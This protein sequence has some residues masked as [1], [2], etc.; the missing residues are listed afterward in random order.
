ME[1]LDTTDSTNAELARRWNAGRAR[2]GDVLR[3]RFQSAGRGRAGREFV[4]KKDEALLISTLVKLPAH[5]AER[6]GWL[7]LAT[8]LAMRAAVST[9]TLKWPNDLQIEGK[10]LGGVLGELLETDPFVAVLGCG[11]NTTATDPYPGA[12]SLALAGLD[13]TPGRVDEIAET[14]IDELTSRITLITSGDIDPLRA[15]LR[16]HLST[17]G[18]SITASV[19]GGPSFGGVAIDVDETG[20]LVLDSG[21]VL[22]QA[23]IKGD[24]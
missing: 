2:H 4:A 8:G 6:A 19:A 16:A 21:I 24:S 10:K 9:A 22:R 18:T 14:F 20:G 17:L 7:T 12:T 23:D 1:L 13:A 15:E 3:A 11:I 5:V